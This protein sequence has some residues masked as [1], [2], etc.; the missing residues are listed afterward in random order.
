MLA[1]R[2]PGKHTRQSIGLRRWYIEKAFHF[3]TSARSSAVE[4]GPLKPKVAG[5]NPAGR[6]TPKLTDET[7]FATEYSPHAV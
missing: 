4:Q 3:I 7:H 5:S 1:L 2:T 6:T